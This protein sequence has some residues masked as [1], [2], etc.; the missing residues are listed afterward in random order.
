MLCERGRIE[1][2]E[3]GRD[4]N[5]TTLLVAHRVS[6][7]RDADRIFVFENGQIVETVTSNELLHSEGLSARLVAS[8]ENGGQ[9]VVI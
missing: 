1:V 7:L 3:Q 4:S 2:G 5:R 6:T 9:R 8:G